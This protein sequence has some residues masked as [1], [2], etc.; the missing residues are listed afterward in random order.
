MLFLLSACLQRTLKFNRYMPN[1]DR[2]VGPLSGT[3]YI[4]QL[5]AEIPLISYIS[6]KWKDLQRCGNEIINKGHNIITTQSTGNL[7]QIPDSSVDYIFTDPPFGENLNYSELNYIWESFIGVVTNTNDEAIINSFQ[8]KGLAEYQGLIEK[9]FK[10]MYRVLKPGRWITVEFHNSK[11]SVW[12]SIQEALSR[13]GFVIA[14]VRVL[15]KKKGTTKQ[16]SYMTTAKQDLVISAYKP[17]EKVLNIMNRSLSDNENVWIFV[18]NHLKQ[19]PIFIKDKNGVAEIVVERTPRVLFDRMV[20]YYVQNGLI[21][22]L[23]SAEFQEGV[24]HRF[25]MRDGMAFLESQL[26]EYDK[27]RLTIKEFMQMELF[28]VGENSAIEWIRQQLLKKPQTRQEIYP[29]FMK[30]IQHIEKHELLPELDDLLSQNFLN[31]VGNSP[32]PDQIVSYLHKNYKD[33]RGMDHNDDYLK[34]K[35]LNRWY[36]PD[37]NKKADLE[38]LR[39]KSLLREFEGYIE[40]LSKSKKKLK[41]F[42]TEAIRAGFKNAWGDKDY[43]KIVMVGDRLPE[44]VI[45]EDDKLLMYYD[46]AQVRLGL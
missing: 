18:E 13:V 45:Q 44:S 19:L 23:S 17:K 35:A 8:R 27:K 26:A 38:K 6:D 43:Q 2:H 20:A 1:H 10:Q 41:Q 30:Q 29:A 39:E 25:P 5:T 37:P 16:M 32:V 3:L 28:V 31:Y 42:R 46:N 4:S 14:D 21:V 22:P 15:D 9:C 36:V 12:N 11:N 34:G 40:E 24:M 33:L 7:E